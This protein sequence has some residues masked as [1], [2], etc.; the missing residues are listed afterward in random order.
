MSLSIE[1]SLF[2][3]IQW[4]GGQF[5]GESISFTGTL[6][7]PSFMASS[8]WL[9]QNFHTRIY[10]SGVKVLM[11]IWTFTPEYVHLAPTSQSVSL[12][13][14]QTFWVFSSQLFSKTV[15]HSSTSFST[16]SKSRKSEMSTQNWPSLLWRS[17]GVLR[18]SAWMLLSGEMKAKQLQSSFVVGRI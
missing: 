11:C 2:D 17:R 7:I 18:S 16:H 8:R 6:P 13:V 12:T 14:R 9:H 1:M 3:P 10:S 5:T 15:L 4:R